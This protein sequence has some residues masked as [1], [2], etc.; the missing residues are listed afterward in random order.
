MKKLIFTALTLTIAIVNFSF[1]VDDT[2]KR[3]IKSAQEQLASSLEKIPAGKETGFGFKNRSEFA[4]SNIGNPYRVLAFTGDFYSDSE[5]KEGNCIFLQNEWRVPV[6]VNGENRLL[7]TVTNDADQYNVVDV[8]GAALAKE[9]QQKN[10]SANNCCLLRV[11]PLSVDFLV[12]SN[13]ESFSEAKYIPMSSALQ[14]IP[15]LTEINQ[16]FYTLH[17]VIHII[18][19]ELKNQSKN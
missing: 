12:V 15:L 10:P 6:T 17:D 8:G 19:E 1:N 18:K 16:P 11:Y 9:L 5:V 3:V 2:Q 14:A 13:S 7:L 4:L